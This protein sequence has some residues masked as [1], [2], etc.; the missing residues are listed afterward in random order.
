MKTRVEGPHKHV[1]D[2]KRTGR[3]Y[4]CLCQD[5]KRWWIEGGYYPDECKP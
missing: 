1:V 5:C 3:L 2:E 4:R